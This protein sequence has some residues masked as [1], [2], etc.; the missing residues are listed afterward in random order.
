MD[1][2]L[3]RRCA[4]CGI[5]FVWTIAEQDAGPQPDLCPGCRKLAPSPGRQR[6]LVKWY[7]RG[8]GYGFITPAEGADVFVHKSG[9]GAMADSL[10]AGQLVEFEASQGVRG[11]QAEQVVVLDADEGPRTVDERRSGG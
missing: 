8:K 10:R 11:M 9:L 1:R 4:E 3:I 2:D 7:S 5:D 6:G